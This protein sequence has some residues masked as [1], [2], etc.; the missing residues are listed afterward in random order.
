MGT[1]VAKTTTD[2]A[3]LTTNAATHEAKVLLAASAGSAFE[4]YDFFL[5]GSLAIYFG[6]LFFPKGSGPAGFLA[7]LA[8]F[9]AGFV[10]RPFG[11]VV[12]GRLGD[13]IGRKYTF[14]ATILIM[15]FS[16]AA[17]AFLPT[18]EQIGWAAPVILV[19]L[20]LAQGLSVGGEY[21]GAAIYVA[22]HAPAHRRGYKTSWIQITPI[23]GQLLSMIV[24]VGCIF[25][26]GQEA[27]A[28]WGW[29]VP[30]ALSLILLAL[31]VYVRLQ[32]NESPAF[33]HMKAEGTLAKSPLLESFT[34]PGN[35]RRLI[36]ALAAAA[37]M[38][39][40]GYASQIQ[41]LYFLQAVLGVDRMT[42]FL[43]IGAAL[44]VATPLFV[45]FGALSDR[46]GRRPIIAAGL[47][48]FVVACFPVYHAITRAANPAL[49]DFQRQT[50]VTVTASNCRFTVFPTPNMKPSECDRVR[51]VLNGAG[52]SYSLLPG[53]MGAEPTT[54]IGNR[55]IVGSDATSLKRTLVEA[56]LPSRADPAQINT[57]AVVLLLVAL[58]TS[59]AAAFGPMAAWLVELF[60]AKV[61]Y[62]SV[63]LPYHL[64]TGLIGGMVPLFVSALSVWAGNVYFGF[65][66]PVIITA[67]AF[68][69]VVMIPIE[70]NPSDELRDET[71]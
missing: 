10:A 28:A 2:P 52:V 13:L 3:D 53:P 37:G 19:I 22:E 26:I 56:G 36:V 50:I 66:Y 38:G 69:M 15:G 4:W 25:L 7:S 39:A 27:F 62:T 45:L 55:E 18:F 54:R 40:A 59:Y 48:L 29:R 31:C 63:S 9:G 61:R 65:W 21:G 12:F 68:L 47:G 35:M 32:L 23:L 70:P 64:G 42:S 41:G 5:Y 11:A 17:V 33:Q 16:T 67:V 43:I 34:I 57:M 6:D 1:L 71:L 8:I 30:F 46:L 24:V 20:R 51:A 49:A 14:L 58:L 44:I 60:P